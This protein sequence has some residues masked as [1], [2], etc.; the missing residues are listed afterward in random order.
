MQNIYFSSDF[1]YNHK[2]LIRSCSN[3]EDKTQCRDYPSIEFHNNLL[4]T[5][6]NK[7]VKENDILYYLGD[8]SFGGNEEV[9]NFRKQINCRNI[10]LILGNHDKY[11]M[12]KQNSFIGPDKFLTI[13]EKKEIKVGSQL[14]VLCHYAMR[15]WNK[16]DRG[17]WMLHGHSHGNL[18]AYQPTTRQNVLGLGLQMVGK[19]I[20]K[21]MDVGIDCHPKFEPFSLEAIEKL[22]KNRVNRDK[23]H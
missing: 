11:I 15:T 23:R 12:Q 22:M 4:I 5:N 19:E 7:V 9:L 17:A 6:I 13:S 10:H 3:W 21:T 1:H 16:D 14:I 20:F 8:W 2:N 18:P